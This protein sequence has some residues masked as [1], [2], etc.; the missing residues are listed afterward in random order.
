MQDFPKKAARGS[1]LFLLLEM[2]LGQL[3]VPI[4]AQH[5]RR[6][7]PRPEPRQHTLALTHLGR[8]R[9]A[10]LHWVLNDWGY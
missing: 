4:C 3:R 7:V 2:P 10:H 6:P 1:A 8:P 5:G 9:S